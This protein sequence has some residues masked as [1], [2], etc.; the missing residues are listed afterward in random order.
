MSLEDD[1]LQS[2]QELLAKAMPELPFVGNVT[3]PDPLQVVVDGTSVPLPA[4]GFGTD[5]LAAGDRVVVLPVSNKY[6]V[7]G[8]L[9]TPAPPTP[10]IDTGACYAGALTTNTVIPSTSISTMITVA[11]P[12]AG[13]YACEYDL[14]WLA[15][16]SINT[17]V[18]LDYSGTITDV[19]QQNVLYVR[20][21]TGGLIR[22]QSVPMLGTSLGAES[23]SDLTVRGT[24]HFTVSDAGNLT[25][26][27]SRA[28]ATVTLQAGST[29]RLVK[30][31]V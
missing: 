2:Q 30:V 16:G 4:F 12:A 22:K 17:D 6:Y 31:G 26:G 5:T 7:L 20:P 3:S 8:A 28:S 27:L 15:S 9:G 24:G 1:I 13:T 29:V 25:V 11:V 14:S 18:R 10:E 19:G 21:S 23:P